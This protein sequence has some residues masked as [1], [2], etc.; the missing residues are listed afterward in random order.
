MNLQLIFWENLFPI[1]IA[2]KLTNKYV[3][4]LDNLNDVHF[5]TIYAK[6]NGAEDRAETFSEM[7]QGRE[8]YN[9]APKATNVIR[10]M[11]CI[12]KVLDDAFVSVDKN[13]Y[14]QRYNEWEI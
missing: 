14:W 2:K 4:G 9:K 13:E 10:K 6:S 12:T 5:V 1:K 11:R 3:Y 8:Q 7:M